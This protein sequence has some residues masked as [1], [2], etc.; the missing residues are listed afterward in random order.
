M[1]LWGQMWE[2]V[3][4]DPGFTGLSWGDLRLQSWAG[5]GN[6]Q[7]QA[8]SLPHGLSPL[9]QAEDVTGYAMPQMPALGQLDA[10]ASIPA[11]K[12]GDPECVSVCYFSAR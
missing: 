2:L 5:T 4:P 7:V 3:V 9:F 1:V 11:R 8:P 6:G 10:A 12:Q